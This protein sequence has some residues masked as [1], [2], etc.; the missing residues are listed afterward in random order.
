MTITDP[1]DLL[2]KQNIGVPAGLNSL[3]ETLTYEQVQFLVT[4]MPGVN[5]ILEGIV[6]YISQ[7]RWNL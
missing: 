1:N 6:D 5:S 3:D 2:I 4:N 7:V